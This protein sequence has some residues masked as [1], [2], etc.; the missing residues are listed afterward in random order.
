MSECAACFPPR[1]GV[2]LPTLFISSNTSIGEKA[3]S[4]R[5]RRGNSCESSP[6]WV[7]V[8]D[9]GSSE[10]VGPPQIPAAVGRRPATA[11]D[12]I[13]CDLARLNCGGAF[14]T[15]RPPRSS[16][17]RRRRLKYFGFEVEAVIEK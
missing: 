10:S 4:S 5:A 17:S 16:A 7:R 3:A 11:Y 13:E 1:S 12:E 14:S 2:E 8:T 15:P 9:S 6:G